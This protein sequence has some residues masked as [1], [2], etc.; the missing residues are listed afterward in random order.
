MPDPSREVPENGGRKPDRAILFVDGNNWYHAL[1]QAG[2]RYLMELD[3]AKIS[4]KLVTPREWCGTRY[5]IGAMKQEWNATDYANQRR[6]L[7]L[8][9]G[10]DDR[11]SVHLGRLEERPMNNPLADEL[12]NWLKVN[13]AGMD[14]ALRRGLEVL[15]K[16]HRQVKTLKE[17]A[18]DVQLAIDMYR[19]AIE[20]RY[21]A[22]YLLS[23]DGDFTPPVEAVTAL[24]KKVYGCT[25][26]PA[27]SSALDKCCQTF[28]ALDPAWFNDRYRWS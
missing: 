6:F 23:A 9:Q 5:Y 19:L 10:D 17:K 28:I 24:G 20:D 13:G 26:R 22:A 15:A 16:K 18:V 3:Y 14:T 12:Y 21:D 2:V 1:D 4:N 25:V 11:I 7:S 27:F 8:I